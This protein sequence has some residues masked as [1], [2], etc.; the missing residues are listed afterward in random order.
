MLSRVVITSLPRSKHLLISWLQSPSELS[1][2]GSHNHF[3]QLKKIQM[4]RSQHQRLNWFW[5]RAQEMCIKSLTLVRVVAAAAAKSLQSCPTLC[6]P[7]DCSLPGFSVH[8]ILQA[9]TQEWVATSFS[10]A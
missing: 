6:D 1:Y 8:G 5:C 9:R 4:F 3:R 10:N 2:Q 7:M